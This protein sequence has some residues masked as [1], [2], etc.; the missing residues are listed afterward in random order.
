MKA[1]IML[2]LFLEHVRGRPTWSLVL[3]GDLVPI[4]TTL[5]T[6]ALCQRHINK[7]SCAVLTNFY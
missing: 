5:S 2:M 1:L 4:A 3:E 6:P 7:P